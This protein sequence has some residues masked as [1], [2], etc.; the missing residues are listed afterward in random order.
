MITI[1]IGTNRPGANA[2]HLGH[3]LQKVYQ[4]LGEEP[5]TLDLIELPPELFTPEAYAEKPDS[6]APFVQKVLDADGLHV[7]VPEYNGG[8]PGV[9]KLFIDH[10]PF[11]ESF[12]NRPVAFTG[13]AAG[14]FGALRPVEQLQ[15]IWAYRNAHLFPQRVFIPGVTQKIGPDGSLTDEAIA[16][17]LHAQCEGFLAF[18]KALR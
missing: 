7:V 14:Q 15:Q 16:E 3:H 13:E 5:A 11:P 1:L 6:F 17:R 2:R 12:E 8:F 18:T 10:L 9:L 4:S